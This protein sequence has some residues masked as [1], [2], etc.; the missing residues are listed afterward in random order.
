M[1]NIL[2]ITGAINISEN[3]NVVFLK[4]TEERLIQYIDSINYAIE[5]YRDIHHIVFCENTNYP[6]DY[7]YL[8]E[9]AKTFNKTLNVLSFKGNLDL[10]LQ[11]GK[12]YGEGEI[13][14]YALNNDK[15]LSESEFF[16]KLTGKLKVKNMD[17]IT[18]WIKE[19][20]AFLARK[21][22]EGSVAI[23]YFYKVKTSF[24]KEYLLPVYA[25][26][27]EKNLI[28]IEHVYYDALKNRNISFFRI[29]PIIEG[30]SGSTGGNYNANEHITNPF[31]RLI[32]TCIIEKIRFFL[33]RKI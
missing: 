23:T 22:R 30:V 8:K 28:N 16:Y 11:K 29:I 2:L 10:I 3:V 15:L 7:T 5:N 32:R 17:S 27:D 14:E 1:N 31:N 19:E 13:I 33:K 6:Y 25:R 26:I 18:R 9:K 12:G 24:F 20:S 4:N 21:K